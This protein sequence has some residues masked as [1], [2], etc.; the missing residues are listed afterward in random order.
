MPKVGQHTRGLVYKQNRR[1][2]IKSRP[3]QFIQRVH[4]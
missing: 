3:K 2:N 4:N 1:S